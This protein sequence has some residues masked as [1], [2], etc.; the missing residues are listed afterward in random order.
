MVLCSFSTVVTTWTLWIRIDESPAIQPSHPHLYTPFN[1]SIL[2]AKCD[3]FIQ[4]GIF[5]HASPDCK[6]RTQLTIV[7]TAK[8]PKDKNNPQYCRIAYDF[9]LLNDRI[10]LDPEPVDSVI[11]MLAWIGDSP[12]GLFSKTDADRGFYQIACADRESIN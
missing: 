4:M 5:T 12:T 7:R 6:D 3:P 11:D 8:D 2:H 10:Q 9:R 1:D